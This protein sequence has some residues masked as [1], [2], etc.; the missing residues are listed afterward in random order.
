MAHPAPSQNRQSASAMSLTALGRTR[1]KVAAR[2]R[3]HWLAMSF[4]L[5]ALMLTSLAHLTGHVLTDPWARFLPPALYL[6][7]FILAFVP[8]LPWVDGLVRR[9]LPLFVIPLALSLIVNA[10]GPGRLLVPL[11]LAVFFLASLGC[12]RRIASDRPAPAL[13]AEFR[14]WVAVGAVLGLLAVILVLPVAF[15]D[16]R[17]YPLVI[18]VA[19]SVRRD[20]T[21]ASDRSA[22]D[23]ALPAAVG[24]WTLATVMVGSQL[25]VSP[26]TTVLAL[27]VPAFLCLRATRRPNRF[28]AA[29][30]MLMIA[31]QAF[32]ADKNGPIL[33]AMWSMFG[34]YRVR[35]AQVDRG[36]G[37]L[38]PER[39]IAP[40]LEPVRAAR[41]S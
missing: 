37:R 27:A 31:G 16:A 36:S 34:A 2:T 33:A 40:Q 7:A 21:R 15:A 20:R 10:S 5:S 18:I 35:F 11:H 24:I 17:L 3:V 22:A 26:R 32:G 23:Y 8:G 41:T 14:L 30:A 9:G 12:H 19:C 39:R 1:H 38:W 25:A 28:A 29:L 6:V 4:A 13:A